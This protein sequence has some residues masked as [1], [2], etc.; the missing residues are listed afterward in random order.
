MTKEEL[1]A[2]ALK[3]T[4]GPWGVGWPNPELCCSRCRAG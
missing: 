2:L 4:K 1:R 3:A